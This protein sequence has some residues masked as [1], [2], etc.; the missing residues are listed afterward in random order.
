MKS[1]THLTLITREKS[2]KSDRSNYWFG[3]DRVYYF[4]ALRS[5]E[6]G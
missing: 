3:V 6:L 1:M 5:N 2:F 4:D